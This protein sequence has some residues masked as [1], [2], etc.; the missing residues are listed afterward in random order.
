LHGFLK[1]SHRRS[2]FRIARSPDKVKRSVVPGIVDSFLERIVLAGLRC[3]LR[4]LAGFL[5]RLT[6]G[7]LER[8]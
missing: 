5:V 6:R 3:P 2:V 7:K 1:A 8:L 4:S